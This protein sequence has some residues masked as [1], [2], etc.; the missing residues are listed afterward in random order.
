MNGWIIDDIVVYHI[1]WLD[2]ES[3]VQVSLR[4][5]VVVRAVTKAIIHQVDICILV[6]YAAPPGL[7]LDIEKCLQ[8]R[9]LLISAQTHSKQALHDTS[10]DIIR[11]VGFPTVIHPCKFWFSACY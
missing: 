7:I 2:V 10:N 11:A 3:R 8:R 9:L 4:L 1:M 5:R 6:S